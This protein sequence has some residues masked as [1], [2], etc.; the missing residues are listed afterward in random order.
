LLHAPEFQSLEAL[1][2]ATDFLVRHTDT[3]G[4][5]SIWLIDIT[6]EEL[7]RDFDSAPTAAE[8]PVYRAIRSK[9]PAVLAGAYDFGV[10]DSDL[11]T[12][13]ALGAI[14]GALGV[15]CV[16]GAQPRWIGCERYAALES[17]REWAAP[18]PEADL[19]RTTASARHIGLTGPRFLLRL[20]Y[21]AKTGTCEEFPFEEMGDGFAHDRLLWG[22]SA[23]LCACLLAA[24][25]NENGWDLRPGTHSN[26]DG[27]P[28]Y[29]H[30]V[31]GETVAQP[32]A[33]TLMTEQAAQAMMDRG[34]MCL[35]S[36]KDS[37]AVRLVRFHNA[38]APAGQ[39]VGPWA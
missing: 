25:F 39:L 38:A 20:P 15:T 21:G 5:V 23:L 9:L 29:I 17:P 18:P 31:D 28:V 7:T 14:A 4:P 34:V 27:L 8:L 26:L 16:V 13:V 12:L 11:E 33:E 36:M 10:S 3:D 1:W 32:C 24:A 37:D 2:R 19:F 30:K 22:N 6:R 35:A